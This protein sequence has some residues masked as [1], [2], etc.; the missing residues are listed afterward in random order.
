M[1]S[2]TTTTGDTD[3]T[4]VNKPSSVNESISLAPKRYPILCPISHEPLTDV[5]IMSDGFSYDKKAIRKYT[6]EQGKTKSPMTGKEFERYTA[7]QINKIGIKE[8]LC[9]DFWAMPNHNVEVATRLIMM[10][11]NDPALYRAAD[12]II[13]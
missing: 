4:G 9:G 10:K 8:L 7:E 11:I 2:K 6:L 13:E 12:A 5:L 1:T 3:R